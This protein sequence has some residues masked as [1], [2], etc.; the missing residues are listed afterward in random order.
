MELSFAPM[1]GVTGYCFRQ[2]HAACFPGVDRYFAPFLAP[3]G[4]GHYRLGALRDLLPENNRDIPLVPQ[5]LCS[6]PEPFLAVARELAAMGYRE[7]NLNAG[8]PSA[9]V[10]PKHKGAG[11]LADLESFDAFLSEVCEHSPLPVS[12]K[13]RMGLES[14]GEFPAIL[15]LYNRYPIS[16]LIIHARDWAGQY[17]S[18]PDHAAFAGAFARSHAPVVYNGNVVSPTAAREILETVPGLTRLMLGRGA[19][20]NPAL[21]RQLRGGE[22]LSARE[23]REFLRKLEDALLQS[24]LGEHYTLGRLKELWYY[25]IHLFPDSSREYKA[26]NRSRSLSDY[27]DAAA[28]LFAAGKFDVCACFRG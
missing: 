5:I 9:T 17:K 8:C 3:D 6:R 24:G 20:A 19:A 4:S 27:R 26:L 23:L 14:T 13:T 2:V 16:E 11:M 18:R 28:A 22:E 15:E 7:V 25:L 21:F 1:E 10:V 12:V